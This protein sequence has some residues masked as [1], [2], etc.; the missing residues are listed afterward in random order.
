[1]RKSAALATVAVLALAGCGNGST[2]DASAD[3]AAAE[4]PADAATET[5]TEK[6][7]AV[8]NDVNDTDSDALPQ[9]VTSSSG[10]R[11]KVEKYAPTSINSM[12]PRITWNN[13]GSIYTCRTLSRIEFNDTGFS[14]LDG[15]I[16][17]QLQEFS[18]ARVVNGNIFSFQNGTIIDYSDNST[19]SWFF[20]GFP[21]T[22]QFSRTTFYSRDNTYYGNKIGEIEFN[23]TSDYVNAEWIAREIVGKTHTAI[24]S[25]W[26][27][28]NSD[29]AYD[30]ESGRRVR[31]LDRPLNIVASAQVDG[32]RDQFIAACRMTF[33]QEW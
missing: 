11:E 31:V 32:E 18:I 29:T 16:P 10:I 15:S 4:A 7:A 9:Q 23:I 27:V 8:S 26:G 2:D 20:K 30:I 21:E 3:Q 33:R 12:F 14:I 13:V 5:P 6:L 25:F 24:Y 28:L 22:Q 17:I 19:A 1:M